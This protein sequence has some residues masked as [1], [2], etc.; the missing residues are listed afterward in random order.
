MTWLR[1]ALALAL[2]S[3]SAAFVSPRSPQVRPRARARPV[4]RH[5]ASKR[6]LLPISM[7]VFVQMLGEG[8][9]I[10]SIPLHLVSFGASAITVGLAT[11]CFSFAQMMFLVAASGRLGRLRVLRACLAG[12]AFASML[13]AF[14]NSIPGI[15]LGRF[16]AGAFAASV[17]VAQAAVTDLVP[18]AEAATALSRVAAA[19]QLG[20]VVGP[21]ASA[22]ATGFLAKAFGLPARLG[23]RVAFAAASLASLTVLAV[24]A[25]VGGQGMTKR[26]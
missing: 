15:L 14:S 9:A 10:S 21:V 4:Q 23:V 13:I 2:L 24:S 1:R 19:S 25:L 20:V 6:A 17:P 16:L 18:G 11:S 26:R 22:A 7:S 8:I 5:A 3:A 12:A